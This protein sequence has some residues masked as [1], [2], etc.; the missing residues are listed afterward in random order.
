MIAHVI[1]ITFGSV[2]Q[3]ILCASSVLMIPYSVLNI[4][5]QTMATAAGATT[6]GRKNI[7]RNAVLPLILAFSI[8]ATASARKI[9]TG[10]VR[11]QK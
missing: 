5:F 11:I 8:T 10:T 3:L 6:M 4:H 7:A 9:P 2:T 1:I